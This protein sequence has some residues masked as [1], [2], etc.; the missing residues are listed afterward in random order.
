MNIF[1]KIKIPR[2]FKTKKFFLLTFIF[3]VFFLFTPISLHQISN[4][5]E[6]LINDRAKEGVKTFEKQTGLKIQWELL[7]FNLLTMTVKLENVQV[8][9]LNT[10]NFQKIQ[11]LH[12]LD[13][14]QK[15]K[16]IS[17]RPSLYSLLFKKQIILS[18]LKIQNGDIYLK[19][20]KSFL[21]KTK[22]SQN[23]ELPIKQFLIKDTNIHLSHKEH[24]LKFS[25]LRSKILQKQAG[26]FYFD[27]FVKAFSIRKNTVSNGFQSFK[28]H[29]F[30]HLDL[31][32]EKDHLVY[33]LAFK[34]SAKKGKVSFEGIRLKNENFQSVTEWMDI[35]FDSRGLKQVNI[36]SSGS[37]PSFLIQKGMNVM[38][39]DLSVSDTLLLYKL[40][41][42]YKNGKGYQGFFEVQGKDVVFRSQR[43]KSFSL[44]GRLINYLL[45][46]DKGLI[47]TQN[48]GDIRLTQGEW[49]FKEKPFQFNFSAET[50]RLSF[51]FVNQA[52]LSLSESSLKGV[53][54]G[55]IHC[56]GIDY[57]TYLQ[58]SI[59]GQSEKISV[60][61][62]NQSEVVSFYGM[63]INSDIEWDNQTLNF[64][65]KGEKEGGSELYLK[66]KYVWSV[67][68]LESS[69]SFF[70]NL[71]E[72][73]RIHAP[74]LVEG[75][76]EIQ[77]GKLVVERGQVRLDGSFNFSLLK[78]YSYNLENISGLYR[79]ENTRLNLFDIK[80]SPGRTN[81]TA[82]CQIDFN[83]ENLALKL[84]SPFF[85]IEDFLRAVRQNISWPVSFKG[86]GAVSFFL[87][88]P[89][90]VPEKKA[91]QLK[92]D[93]FN[94]AM[95]RDVFQ[96]ATLD[97]GIQ[98]GKG[99]VRTLLFKKDQGLI[100]GTGFFDS[101]YSLNLD[102]TG[103]KLSL[104]RLEWLNEILPFNQS[105]DV[106][107]NMKVTGK[108]NRPKISSDV[109]ISN[110]FFYSYP[111][112]DSKIQL[113]VDETALS[114]SGH[115]MDKIHINRFV[116][117]FSEKL[118]IEVTGRFAGLDFVEVLLSKS[119]MEKIQDYSSQSSGFFSFVKTG[120]TDP[121]WRG[122]AKIN[123][124][125]ISKSNKW[126]KSEKP[127]SVFFEKDKWSLT[128]ASF[129]HHN[130]KKL[131]IT[132]R[133][134]DKLFL[135]GESFLGL[136]SVFLPFIQEFDGN[137]KGQVLIDNNLKQIHP[138]GS[139]QIKDGL[140]AIS[141]LPDFTQVKASLVFLKN[142]IFINDFSSDVQGGLV[143]GEGSVFYDFNHPPHLS[144]NL[145]FTDVHLNLPE[146]FNTRGDGEIHIKGETP[147]Y[148]ISGHYLIDSGAI[149]RD[150]SGGV[151][152]AK[153]DFSFLE[154][155]VE[156]EADIFQLK[157][158]IK[159][160][161]AVAL[162]SSLIRSSIEGQADLYGPLS[163][164]LING[165][166]ALS[167][168][169]EENL[170]FFRGQE[171]KISSGHILFKHSAPDNP[172]L[173]IKA[174]TVFKEKII[175]RLKS[176]QEIE[177]QYKIFLSLEGLSQNPRFSLK[178]SPSLNEKEIISLL[179]LGVRFRHFEEN[180][181]Q[182]VAD[183][184]YQ[185]LG[186]LLLE[187]SL[188]REIKNL[189]DLDFRLTPYI[190][191]SNKPITKITLSRNWFEKWRTSFSR[192]IEE[193]ALS[194][195]RLKYDLSKKVSLTAF[196]EDIKQNRF[197]DSQEENRLGLDIEFNLD[198]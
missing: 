104:E 8:T 15:I 196:W 43:L 18:K 124:I 88:L 41:I 112:N 166:F 62:T 167:Q 30:N 80:G 56:S 108:P 71:H 9:P 130:N 153:Y 16:K 158:N 19:T 133:D 24:S 102:V 118:K 139:L 106:R 176:E 66:G 182:H 14:Q 131:K 151:Q 48:Q 159:T 96:Q 89:W 107:F 150:F 27:F 33:Q 161:Q 23:I 114:F 78:L 168:E 10:S 198:F 72:D 137:I 25:G 17:A 190:N 191:T 55:L 177:R 99:I 93:F 51:D 162:N 111:V 45:A 54:T 138:R 134:N 6:D 63:N 32:K 143:K 38:S 156:E 126:I 83:K 49:Y 120:K 186:S 68:R 101:S 163:S 36:R 31:K 94:M 21:K 193:E 50:E 61:P 20:L 67:D 117:P 179:T 60:Q 172:Y 47:E 3:I 76:G 129:S 175:D 92:G 7:N 119:R 40:N 65:V 180:V 115:I 110:M 142:D 95:D 195:V 116:Y 84:K 155:E 148:L 192:T 42:Q 46:V 28:S 39:I 127:F 185:I 87:N 91:F 11:E 70:G 5:V 181:T 132:K 4:R 79:L 12:F 122:W 187:K 77:N 149:T 13:G 188:N 170:I 113:K 81:Y 85:D 197:E 35:H 26:I 152:K 141:P 164:L 37:L 125:F 169:A 73:L 146:D 128:P 22:A 121:V 144:L 90:S 53:F 74:F 135:H 103:Q 147:P 75:K 86:T 154:E 183:Y 34:G 178:S 100:R 123:Q 105:G 58:C 2:F 160:K 29:L 157:L 44:K 171:F 98:N 82:K 1:K 189:L 109:S 140:F 165:Q 69:Y 184:S 145:N 57:G 194:D 136:F 64:A 52:V 59:Q 97:F 173:N 174:N